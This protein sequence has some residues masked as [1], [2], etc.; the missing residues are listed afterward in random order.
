M[1]LVG[2]SDAHDPRQVPMLSIDAELQL[3]GGTSARV[4][5]F[6]STRSPR[7][8][9]PETLGEFLDAPRR[10]LPV[11]TERGNGLVARDAIVTVRVAK[12]VEAGR[13]DAPPPAIDMVRIALENGAAI[14]GVLLHPAAGNRAR[15]SDFFNT[16]PDFFAVE[17]E[18]GIVHVSK[19]RV[20]SITF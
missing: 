19:R 2:M 15:L 8:D 5:L 10:F 12:D 3:A 7:H 17:D 1:L 13:P 4:T 16:A 11:R 9:G 6:L 14:D 20:V 18:G